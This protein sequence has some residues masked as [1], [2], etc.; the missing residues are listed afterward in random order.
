MFTCLCPS[1]E[2]EEEEKGEDGDDE[3]DACHGKNLWICCPLLLRYVDLLLMAE[4]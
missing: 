2:E 1:W 4:R 3:Y